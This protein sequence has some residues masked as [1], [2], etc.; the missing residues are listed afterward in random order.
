MTENFGP[1]GQW[2]NEEKYCPV[3]KAMDITKDRRLAGASVLP[4]SCD[5]SH[6]N[7]YFLLGNEKKLPR[8]NDA[9]KWSD[10]GGS[11]K[12]DENESQCAGREFHEETVAAVRWDDNENDRRNFFVRQSSLPIIRDL[13]KGNFTFKMIT[14]IDDDQYYATYVKQVPFDGSVH[15]RTN[16]LLNGLNR[17]RTDIKSEGKHTLNS[18]E[19]HTLAEHPSVRLNVN[20]EAVG[21]SKDFLEKQS[22]QWLSI[23][24]VQESLH[25]GAVRQP[26]VF[27]DSFRQ[28]MKVVL[29]QFEGEFARL[30]LSEKFSPPPYK[31]S[32]DDHGSRSEAYP[33]KPTKPDAIDRSAVRIEFDVGGEERPTL[34][35]SP[36]APHRCEQQNVPF[37][38]P[39]PK[40]CGHPFGA[41]GAEGQV[42]GGAGEGPWFLRD[43]GGF[44]AALPE[45]RP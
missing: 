19:K 41:P 44:E 35:Q 38:E 1:V 20:D 24:Q 34:Q 32:D 26:Y 8:W 33:I 13:E 7:I 39:A 17:M 30:N 37:G 9:N 6:G 27:R 2:G 4:Y 28:R 45:P 10:F 3:S 23:A 16:N 36:T 31:R 22:I 14:L 43:A 29:D 25:S 40:V 11:P 42:P 12:K 18:F 21:V 15:R 5:T